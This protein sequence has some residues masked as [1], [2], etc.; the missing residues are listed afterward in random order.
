MEHVR[1]QILPIGSWKHSAAPG[2]VLKIT[3][4]YVQE[5]A[6]NFK[7]NQYIPVFRGHQKTPDAN[8]DP[9]LTIVKNI[10]KLEA[11]DEGL[12]AE[13][14]MD[15]KEL[16][17]YNDV[18]A[19]IAP[20]YMDTKTGHIVGDVIDHIAMVLKPHI[21]GMQPF[22]AL[23]EE[24]KY[25]I[26]LSEVEMENTPEVTPEAEV[27]ETPVVETVVPAVEAEVVTEVEP[28]VPV[29][30]PTAP[31]AA[32]E[33]VAETVVPVVETP[34]EADPESSAILQTQLQ[35]ALTANARLQ[36]ELA[37][38]KAEGSYDSL[39]KQAKIMPSMKKEYI[40]LAS[41]SSDTIDLA[42]G[43][44]TDVGAVLRDLFN[45]MPKLFNLEESGTDIEQGGKLVDGIS[46]EMIANLS[47]SFKARNPDATEADVKAYIEANKSIIKQFDN[48]K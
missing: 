37:E 45:K 9:S 19:S 10:S 33:V 14:D 44:K 31:E 20:D 26:L 32:P 35:D 46:E 24:K 43:K 25:N 8:A 30:E 36:V 11:T 12:Y 38:A 42:D 28:V 41:K 13:F 7:Y 2:G 17:N 3:K 1:K 40:I 27:V 22:V 34:V 47:S 15:K 4:D 6:N 21:K 5:L 16:D 23:Q 29:V 18:S 48:K 39:L